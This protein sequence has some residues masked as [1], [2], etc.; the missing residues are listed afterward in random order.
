MLANDPFSTLGLTCNITL[1][2][3]E[4]LFENADEKQEHLHITKL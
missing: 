2:V 4:T 1:L 3:T